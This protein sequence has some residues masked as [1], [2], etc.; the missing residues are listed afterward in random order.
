MFGYKGKKQRV[1]D[2]LHERVSML[3]DLNKDLKSQLDYKTNENYRLHAEGMDF[4]R[5]ERDRNEERLKFR[6]LDIDETFLLKG[7]P[8]EVITYILMVSNLQGP[9]V[10]KLWYCDR[11]E[12]I[13]ERREF[14]R[15]AQEKHDTLNYLVATVKGM[16]I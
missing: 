12:A 8:N 5:A 7:V 4:R 6:G 9:S 16:G 14:N 11:C 15:H 13:V 10:I 3:N 1:I 2:E